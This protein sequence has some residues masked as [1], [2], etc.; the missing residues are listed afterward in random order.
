[1]RKWALIILQNLNIYVFF[2]Y[3]APQEHHACAH[4]SLPGADVPPLAP[5]LQD[6]AMLH[7]SLLFW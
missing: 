5:H 3:V 2:K 7:L 4:F 6:A 1:M